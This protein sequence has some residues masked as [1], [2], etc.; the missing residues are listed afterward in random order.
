MM[1][2]ISQHAE[3]LQNLVDMTRGSL[4]DASGAW[5]DYFDDLVTRTGST[6]KRLLAM[7]KAFGAASALIDAWEAHNK[8]L[9]DPMLPWWAR[10]ASAAQVLASGLGAVNAIRGVNMG[11]AGGGGGAGSTAAA[12]APN[13][14]L[15]AI[16]RL[17]GPFASA[18]AG[19][20]GTIFDM[21][22]EEAGDRGLSPRVVGIA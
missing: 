13:Q 2:A 14:P 15:E 11:G 9:K 21:L 12:A 17:Q 8:V 3:A 22:R 10:I 19:E 7:A 16:V 20:I 1:E 18:L 6:N 4:G 5:G